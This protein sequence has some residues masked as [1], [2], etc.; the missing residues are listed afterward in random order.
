MYESI[1]Q[2]IDAHRLLSGVQRLL[3]GVSGGRDSMALVHIMQ[4][5]AGE[6][7]LE[8]AVAHFDHQLRENSAADAQFVQDYCQNAAIPFYLGS[9]DVARLARQQGLSVEQAARQARHEFFAQTRARHGYDALALAHHADDQAETFLLRLV[10]GAGSTGLAAMAPREASG[11]LRPLLGVSRAEIDEYCKK[12][13]LAWREDHTNADM[14]I[15]RNRVRHE[16]LPYLKSYFNPEITR[17]LN[18]SAQLLRR[19]DSCLHDQAMAFYREHGL[20][21]RALGAAP[22][23]ISSRALRIALALAG[24]PQDVEERH[25][26]AL[27]QLATHGRTGAQVDL[28]SGFCVARD[29]ETLTI[30]RPQASAAFCADAPADGPAILP[31]GTAHIAPGSRPAQFLG[32]EAHTQWVDGGKLQAFSPLVWRSRMPGDYFHPLGAPGG[33]SLGDVLTDK[34]IPR[35]LRDGLVLLCSKSQVLWAV[36]VGLSQQVA[37]DTR[38]ETVVELRYI[39]KEDS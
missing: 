17:V 28:G 30:F 3:L 31:G 8:L 27:L 26:T 10:R 29:A 32:P 4:A 13:G 22:L 18:R 25:I 23:P 37:L 6:Y 33:K 12:W 35:R 1:R 7:R 38:T 5:L 24:M 36:G 19:D 16:L 34:K 15:P 11:I 39:P 9:A 2:Y 14:D 21:A 20:N